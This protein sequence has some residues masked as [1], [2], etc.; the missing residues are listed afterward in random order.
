MGIWADIIGIQPGLHL[1]HKW[2]HHA[3]IALA[4]LSSLVV[5]LVMST[6]VAYSNIKLTNANTYSLTLLHYTLGRVGTT[7]LDDLDALTGYR[8][9][10]GPRGDV[11][12]VSRP[13]A[14][15]TIHCENPA[16]YVSEASFT[17]EGIKYR[18][19][20]DRPGQPA[21]EPRYCAATQ[22][23]A[24]TSA[25][26]VLVFLPDSTL[27]RKQNTKGLF[28]GAIAVMAWLLSYWTCY[29]RGLIPIYA[30]RRDARRRR[31]R[32]QYS[33]S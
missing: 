21:D 10:F 6:V 8:G 25:D 28:I 33:T 31:R 2:W 4:V 19:I 5:Y 3:A 15:E 17:I 24:S 20:P 14:P 22:A 16:H 1:R 23:Y 9:R 12:L 18:T 26:E 27:V 32:S 29:Y 13:K 30:R 11:V 7:T